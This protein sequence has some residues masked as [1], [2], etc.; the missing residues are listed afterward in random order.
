MKV[1]RVIDRVG[2]CCFEVI[3]FEYKHHFLIFFLT[4]IDDFGA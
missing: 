4:E 1:K 3:D 2:V